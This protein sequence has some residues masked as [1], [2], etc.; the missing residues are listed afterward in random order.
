MTAIH[1]TDA[2][3][4]RPSAGLDGSAYDIVQRMLPCL[5]THLMHSSRFSSSDDSI[6]TASQELSWDGS[7]GRAD[8]S[9]GTLFDVSENDEFDRAYQQYSQT[10]HMGVL[11]PEYQTFTSRNGYGAVVY[12]VR[13]GTLVVSGDPLA[14]PEHFGPLLDELARFRKKKHLKIAFMGVSETFA[15]YAQ[16][17]RWI[18]LKVGRERVLN[19]ITN[20]ILSN[21]GAGKRMLGQNRRLLDPERGAISIGVYAP[22]I[23]GVD[24]AMEVELQII[25]DQWR[26]ERNC[27]KEKDLQ[28]FV[29]VYDLFCRRNVTFFLYTSDRDGR[30]NG[31]AALRNVGARSGFH[32][33]PC[34][35]SPTAPRGITDLLIVT[36]MRLL[37]EAGVSYMCLGHEPLLDLGDM[38]NQDGIKARV[39]RDMFH[40]VVDSA[41]L[42]GK[43]TY[44]D[45]F[46]PDESQS[47]ELYVVLP[48]GPSLLRQ[49]AAVMH[50]ANIRIRRLLR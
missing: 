16:K 21:Q 46:H 6:V 45:K 13:D 47:S 35:A 38:P 28:T 40:R 34:I 25:Y 20:K 33:D 42:G 36:A 27:K 18:P 48:G 44:N 11:D 30:V 17:R 14:A 4:R 10:A 31:F 29:T 32:L 43:R 37:R 50:V 23:H 1:R 22:G 12:T 26:A 8:S 49:A 41:Q 7:S 2:S 9:D 3:A 24:Q 5:D 39:A 15:M 19:P